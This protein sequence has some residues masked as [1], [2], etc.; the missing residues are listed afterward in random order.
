M[1]VARPDNW[2]TGSGNDI[3]FEADALQLLREPLRALAKFVGK[4]IVG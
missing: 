4:L 1:F 3:G 2:V